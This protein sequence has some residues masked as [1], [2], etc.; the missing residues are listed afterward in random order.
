MQLKTIN[1]N[2]L[3]NK[4]AILLE[5]AYRSILLNE[6]SSEYVEKIKKAV[7]DKE[8][9]FDNI[10]GN[11]LRIIIPLTGTET[12]NQIK[13]EITKI[14][15]YSGFDPVKKEIIK[16]IKLDAKYGGGEKEQRINLGK[17][18]SSLK[19]SDEDKKK[20][21]NWFA[22]YNTNLSELEDMSNFSIVISRSPID[23]L[24][25]SDAGSIS[26][27][28]S[29]GGTYFHCAME[30]ARN[31][32]PI[33]FLVNTDDLSDVSEYSLQNEEIFRDDERDIEGIKPLARIRIRRYVDIG[34]NDIAV[35][36]VRI[37]GAKL[38]GFYNSVKDFLLKNQPRLKEYNIPEQFAKRKITRTGGSYSDS[39]DSA[40]FNSMFD[41]DTFSGSLPHDSGEEDEGR[42]EQF[43]EELEEYQIRYAYDLKHSQISFSVV[44]DGGEVYYY[45][46]ASISIK[47]GDL[48]VDKEMFHLD[49]MTDLNDMRRYNPETSTKQRFGFS[50]NFMSKMHKFMTNIEELETGNNIFADYIM[51]F[52]LTQNPHKLSIS[53]RN[54]M[55]SESNTCFDT[56]EYAKFCRDI[57]SLD[58]HYEQ[59]ERQIIKAMYNSGLV[60]INIENNKNLMYLEDPS[61]IFSKLKYFK[62]QESDDNC[63]LDVVLFSIPNNA[64]IPI[65]NFENIITKGEDIKNA[66]GGFLEKYLTTHLNKDKEDVHPTFKGFLESLIYKSLPLEHF[67]IMN[68]EFDLDSRYEASE[69][70]TNI[71]LVLDIHPKHITTIFSNVIFFLDNHID[72]I[73]NIIKLFVFRVLKYRNDYT[74]NIE[75]VYSKY[76]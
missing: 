42:A 11:K 62:H 47:L 73:K 31:G 6:I 44:D 58:E 67:G 29:E 20:Y 10:F 64:G 52:Y 30:E 66:F 63:Y 5:S 51:S 9:P 2:M 14:P 57:K 48:V 38:P 32:G 50:E 35:P 25:M 53:L 75:K 55:D 26:S 28:H 68:F 17:A 27:C 69:Q 45:V 1:I 33:A 36:E 61:Q 22:N 34:K 12:Y 41:V 39:S 40:L 46:D 21:L 54:G 49:G 71:R 56:D 18:I 15:N 74:R 8:L 7:K 16:K 76:I 13:Q 37:Y 19:I 23:V 70:S 3:K 65:K 72:D 59:C 60:N 43:R 4:D 24:R